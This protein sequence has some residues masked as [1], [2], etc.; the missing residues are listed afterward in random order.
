MPCVH[1]GQFDPGTAQIN[2]QYVHKSFSADRSI[3]RFPAAFQIIARPMP[4]VNRFSFFF[5][6]KG[7]AA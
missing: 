2:A 6:G 4:D 3:D 1:N 5:M 7:A